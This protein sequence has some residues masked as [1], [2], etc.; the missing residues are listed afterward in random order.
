MLLVLAGIVL[1]VY[2]GIVV[3]LVGGIVQAIDAVKATPV[4]SWG[5]AWG[6]AKFLCAGIVGWIV[7]L[8]FI[9]PGAAMIQD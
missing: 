7:A 6:I 5:V 3:C 8:V 2:V 1:G 4:D 9:I